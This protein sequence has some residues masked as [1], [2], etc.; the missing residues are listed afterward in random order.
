MNAPWWKTYLNTQVSDGKSRLTLVDNLGSGAFGAVFLAYSEGP[1]PR[2]YAVKIIPK[3]SKSSYQYERIIAE[4]DLHQRISGHPNVVT[5]HSVVEDAKNFFLVLD[6]HTGG[7]LFDSLIEEQSVMKR[8]EESITNADGYIKNIFLQII[9]AVE[10]CH[11]HDVFHCDLK[12]ENILLSGDGER[13]YLADFGLATEHEMSPMSGCGSDHYMSPECIAEETTRRCKPY[14]TRHADIWALG[15]ILFNLV[16]ACNPWNKAISSDPNFNAY[17]GSFPPDT[18]SHVLYP[19]EPRARDIDILYTRK[20]LSGQ[21]LSR[22]ANELF[23]DIFAIDPA[24]RPTLGSLRLRV[25]KLGTFYQQ[26]HVTGSSETQMRPASHI[27]S[28]V[29][30]D[31]LS[32]SS[33]TSDE[34]DNSEGPITPETYAAIPVVAD[35]DIPALDMTEEGEIKIATPKVL[36]QAAKQDANGRTKQFFLTNAGWIKRLV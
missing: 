21:P 19:M 11:R 3:P 12:P 22:Y 30:P 10:Y 36:F 2:K 15:V 1:L 6:Y 28:P 20:N 8:K 24:R 7:D 18:Y 26:T 5:L 29:L 13:A 35:A 4:I 14:S 27:F 34:S 31:A 16:T 23:R 33:S 17:L 32:G 9:S 25:Q